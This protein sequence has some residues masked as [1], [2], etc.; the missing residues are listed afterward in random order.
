VRNFD[1]VVIG[2][3]SGN[4]I[5]D[6]RFDDLDVAILEQ[7]VFG[8]TC[9]NVGCIPTKMYVY[10][11]E[12]ALAVRDA[13]RFG[14]DAHVDGVRWRDIVDRVFG[15]I[16]PIS[17]GGATYRA[18]GTPNTTLFTGH[19]RFVGPRTI[20]TGTGET[21]TA[22]R[23][24]IAAGSRPV[25]PAEIR[26]SGVPF[27]TNDDVMRLPELPE[28]LVILGAGYIASE[29]AHVFSAL[30]SRVTVIARSATM[31]RAQ[32]ED[33][34]TRFTHLA[35]EKWDVR[36]ERTVTAVR[37]TGGA[38]EVEL[39]DGSVVRGDTLL[40]A[41]GRAPNG[42]ELEV[43]AGG[44]GLHPDGRIRVDAQQRVLT[45]DGSVLDGVFAL[46]DISSEH[47]LKHV[48]NH[49][50]R[51]VQHNLLHPDELRASDHRFVPAAVFTDPQI[52]TVGLT[53][54]AAREQGLDITVK[55]QEYAD[56]AYGWAME[57]RE[58]FCKVIAEKGTGRLLG[59]HVMGAQASSIIQP[60]I[61]ALSFGLSA[62]DMAT[63][64]YWI[65]PGLPEVLEN[66]LLGLEV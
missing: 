45:D 20:E 57:D 37:G 18:E 55:V 33:V 48:A 27:H 40:V 35:Q 49:E 38:V 2:S 32:D 17:V 63:G 31:L 22:D 60:A 25:I 30:G 56:V 16:D 3:G 64:Q 52:A 58:G 65:H 34:S 10:A 42:D 19:A 59:V 51:V 53:E 12:Q 13:H 9:I 39:D 6:N 4:T 46:G 14:V 29:F 21:I 54:R 36:L 43:A 26:D 62:T 41:A 8:G 44:A 11:A 1:L 5:L 66:A 7:G 15:R 50:A 61:Q 23:V 24:V 47:Q 28:H